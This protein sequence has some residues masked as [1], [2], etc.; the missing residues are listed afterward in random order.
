MNVRTSMSAKLFLINAAMILVVGA[1]I[2]GVFWAFGNIEQLMSTLIERDVGQMLANARAGREVSDVF[3]ETTL[4]INAFSEERDGSE[5]GG[6]LVATVGDLLARTTDTQMQEPLQNFLRELETLLEQGAVVSAM[7]QELHASEREQAAA[8][9]T[10]EDQLSEMAVMAA[11]GGGDSAG[12]ERLSLE[13]YW[14]REALLRTT[15][16]LGALKQQHFRAVSTEVDHEGHTAQIFSLLDDFD[17]RLNPLQ[18]SEPDIA[19]LGQQLVDTNQTYKAAIAVFGRELAAFQQRFSSLNAAQ[20]HVSA[21]MET[22][23][24]RIAD[25]AGSMQGKIAAI[26]RSSVNITVVLA[27]GV[28][29]GLLYAAYYI[30]RMLKPLTLLADTAN[31]LAQGDMTREIQAIRSRDE[32]GQSLLAMNNMMARVKQVIIDVQ[33]AADSVASGSQIMSAGAAEMSQGANAQAASVEEVSSS[34]EQMVANI[35]QNADNAL[36]TEK[37]AV[38][39]AEDAQA[40]GHAV[41]EVVYAMQEIAQKIGLIEDIASQ[42]RLLSLNAT[43]E[44]ARAQDYG[45]GFA[46]VA[47]EVRT[48]SEQ[49]NTAAGDITSLTASGLTLAENAGKRL[50]KL[51]PD[52]QQTAELVQEIS[53]ASREQSSGTEQIN[54]AIRQLDSGTQ[55]NAITSEELSSTAEELAQQAEQL[56]DAVAFFKVDTTKREAKPLAQP[57]QPSQ[58]VRAHDV[59]RKDETE[60]DTSAGHS[61]DLKQGRDGRDARDDEFEWY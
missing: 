35:R 1:A 11:M 40:G 44:A 28:M 4:L 2:A 59:E 13:I 20:Q 34:M 37:I 52:I 45:K 3:A 42:T 22:I 50:L 58:S 26:I 25:T 49:T 9:D 21:A 54:R 33:A 12:F 43:I 8:L 6:Q 5:T 18:D 56:Q 15:T 24:S 60:A 38:K 23:D 55:E 46:V 51:V 10:L 29:I 41:A 19:A 14:Y 31:Q 36:Q 27:V 16:Q 7:S 30:V 39:A 53:A 32:I 57:P 48:L 61:I 47:A 17:M